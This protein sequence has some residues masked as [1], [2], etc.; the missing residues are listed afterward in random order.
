MITT[1]VIS[2]T[3]ANAI[4]TIKVLCFGKYDSRTA[5]QVAPFG[6]DS[7]PIKDMVAIYSKT[8]NDAERVII[9]YFNQSLLADVG[10][11]RIYA[12]DS[13]GVEKTRVWLR[14]NGTI[15]I[16]GT[17]SG[18]NPN[19]L[20][21]WE[22]LSTAMANLQT[23]LDDWEAKFN[24]HT[25]TIP[26]GTSGIPSSSYSPITIDIDLSKTGTILIE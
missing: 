17:G 8:E 2:Q 10:E 25:H 26:T 22:D 21:R 5:S 20:T 16:G 15:N 14:D 13:D 4:R 3:V 7:V 6:I 11:I 23:Q 24:I 18:D 12:T 1:K 19:H 9:G